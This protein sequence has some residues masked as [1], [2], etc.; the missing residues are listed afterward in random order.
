MKPEEVLNTFSEKFPVT[1]DRF[2]K[3]DNQ[4]ISY[5]WIAR[6]DG[7]RDFLV[8]WFDEG[9]EMNEI[10]FV[11]SSAKYSKPICEWMGYVHT[12]CTP[13]AELLKSA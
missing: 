2:V 10:S 3:N 4:Y 7:Q 1:W 9:C 5:G 12:D 6:K 13:A 11:T 8:L